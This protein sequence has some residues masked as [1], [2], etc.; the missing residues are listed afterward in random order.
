MLVLG[1]V[2]AWIWGASRPHTTTAEVTFTVFTNAI[3]TTTGIP[4]ECLSF[5]GRTVVIRDVDSGDELWRGETEVFGEEI[6]NPALGCSVGVNAEEILEV[7]RYL[8]T[9]GGMGEH[10]YSL[11][12]LEDSHHFMEWDDVCLEDPEPCGV[13]P[14]SYDS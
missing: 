3:V 10:I 6:R 13:R 14:P 1:I 12:S 5:A 11:E 7:P 4:Q 2:G 9:V 8:V